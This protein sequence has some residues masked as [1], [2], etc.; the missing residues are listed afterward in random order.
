[1]QKIKTNVE[2][3][4]TSSIYIIIEP[5]KN[6]KILMNMQNPWGEKHNQHHFQYCSKA[7][8]GQVLYSSSRPSAAN[9]QRVLL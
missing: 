7:M 6:M 5:R 2:D 1:M 4:K 9:H 8:M 3:W